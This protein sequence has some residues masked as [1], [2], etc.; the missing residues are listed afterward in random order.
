MMK[1]FELF[2]YPILLV[3][4]KLIIDFLKHESKIPTDADT[5]FMIPTYKI[6]HKSIFEKITEENYTE[7][8]TNILRI[9]SYLQFNHVRY[10]VPEKLVF[11]LDELNNLLHQKSPEIKKINKIYQ[12]F[13]NQYHFYFNRFKGNVFIFTYRISSKHF[14]RHLFL[15][16][17]RLFELFFVVYLLLIILKPIVLIIT[18]FIFDITQLYQ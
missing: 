5:K 10:H 9:Y 8:R 7:M 12:C 18:K 3:V 14:L 15:S 16:G 17:L 4:I 11:P 2:I 13:C 1:T 6:L